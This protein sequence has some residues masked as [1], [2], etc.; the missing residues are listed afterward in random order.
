M[1][2]DPDVV[3]GDAGIDVANA[4]NLVDGAQHVR[5]GAERVV[6]PHVPPDG[7]GRVEQRR[8]HYCCRTADGTARPDE[9]PDSHSPFHN[10]G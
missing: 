8:E 1:L 6:E 2:G 3:R 9:Q 4:K 10:E 5:A 7:F